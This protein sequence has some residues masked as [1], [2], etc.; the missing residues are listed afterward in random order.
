MARTRTALDTFRRSIPKENADAQLS[1][2]LLAF[3]VSWAT[4]DTIADPDD[5]ARAQRAAMEPLGDIIQKDPRYRDLVYDMLATQLPDDPTGIKLQPMQQLALAYINSRDQLGQTPESK[6]RLQAALEAARAARDNLASRRPEKLEG[7]FLSAVCNALLGNFR[8]A[9]T[10]EIDFAEQAFRDPRARPMLELSLKHIGDLR[11]AA[12]AAN[13]PIPP[14]LTALALRALQLAADTFQEKQWLYRQG[15][16]L[17]EAGKISDAMVVYEKVAAQDPSY[18]EARYR[19]VVMAADKFTQTTQPAT[20]APPADILAAATALFKA[21][22]TFTA[23]LENPPASL[24]AETLATAKSY[25]A[26]IWL[27]ETATALHPAVKQPDTALDRL[28]KLESVTDQLAEPQRLLALRY[29]IQA[30]QLAD[31]PEETR[32]VVTAYIKA[33]P[34]NAMNDLRGMALAAVDEVE[35]TEAT[36]PAQAKRQVRF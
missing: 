31:K 18:F 12:A 29:R 7:L 32:Q 9:A 28:K 21:C 26:N 33:N 11:A 20:K 16:I 5:R 25:R 15:R 1:G 19:L 22:S 30:Y 8:D 27:I 35:K 24:P 3:R 6:A 4:S 14:E 17:E 34:T 36:D 2:E 10:D 23:L 13:Q